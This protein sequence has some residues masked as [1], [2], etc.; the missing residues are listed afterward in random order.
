[1]KKRNLVAQYLRAN[2]KR[3][4]GQHKPKRKDDEDFE[5]ERIAREIRMRSE[6]PHLYTQEKTDEKVD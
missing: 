3:N 6:Q 5:F 4:A 1:M 2:P